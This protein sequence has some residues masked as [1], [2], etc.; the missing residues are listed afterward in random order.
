[1]TK[2]PARRR[3]QRLAAQKRYEQTAKG[4]ACLKRWRDK[5]IWLA[6]NRLIGAAATADEAKAINAYIQRRKRGFIAGQSQ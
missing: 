1:M 3:A 2:D 4:K 5:R 6:R